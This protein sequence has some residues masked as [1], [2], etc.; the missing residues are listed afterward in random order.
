M[1][2]LSVA[3]CRLAMIVAAAGLGDGRCRVAEAAGFSPSKV[4]VFGD[5]LSDMGNIE[6]ATF[7]IVPGSSYYNG[8]FSNGPAWVEWL[9][10]DLGVG[11]LAPSTAGGNN[12]AY[13]GGQTSGAGGIGGA[14][15]RDVDEQLSQY[16]ASR[17]VDANALYVVWAGANDLFDGETNVN[18]PVGRIAAALE[19]LVAA[20][21]R[22]FLVPSLPL[23][24]RIPQYNRDAAASAAFD[25]LSN[26]YN[27]AFE[28][29]IEQLAAANLTATFYRL[30]VAAIFTDAI[31][32]PAQ[33]GLSNVRDPAAPGLNPGAL[34]YDEDRIVAHPEQYLFWDQIHPTAAVHAI[35]GDYASRLLEGAPGDFDTDGEVD[36]WDLTLWRGGFGVSAAAGRQGDA[37]GDRDV[38]GAD[39][40]AWQRQ[41]GS[42]LISQAR[43]ANPIAVPEPEA[44]LVAT[45]GVIGLGRARRRASI[46]R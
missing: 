35:L 16:F 1:R 6:A 34:F 45:F 15:I 3:V 40:L 13:G 42:D 19:A 10:G 37:D 18:A 36:A 32:N 11:P 12:F 46:A 43:L 38:D 14:F 30:D 17:S 9:A 24:G 20:G 21:A 29:R 8:R 26:E 22:Q 2:T 39:F 31:N 25:R 4:I 27:A 33:W 7:G 28:A 5:S 41:L 44:A 23:L